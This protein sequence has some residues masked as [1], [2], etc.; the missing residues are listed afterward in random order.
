MI[1]RLNGTLQRLAP[2]MAVLTRPEKERRLAIAL[3]CSGV[4]V[5]GLHKFY[6]RQWGWGVFYLLLL[7]THIPQVASLIEGLWYSS[8]DSEEFEHNFNSSSGVLAAPATP[9]PSPSPS[10][11]GKTL[12]RGSNSL[13]TTDTTKFAV[14]SDLSYFVKQKVG[15]KAGQK[16]SRKNTASVSKGENGS[17]GWATSDVSRSGHPSAENNSSTQDPIDVNRATLEDWLRVPGLTVEQGRSLVALQAQ[18]VQFHCLED[19]A[20]ALSLPIEQLRASEPL[21]AFY[22]YEPTG[23]NV[24]DIPPIQSV[25]PNQASIA[26][27]I[28]LPGVDTALALQI[29]HHRTRPYLHL[30]DL[31]QRL[32]LTAQQ[33][34]HLMHYLHF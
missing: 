24:D 14:Q 4:L 34:E 31:Q 26:S 6:L 16:V 29:A 3:A 13:T 27:L 12:N 1:T 32:R 20:A 23:F 22:Y 2:L 19:L 17:V 25:N 7:P 15:Q 30:A 10:T 8:L 11:S 9:S 21:L 33:V 28:K 5:P 18:G